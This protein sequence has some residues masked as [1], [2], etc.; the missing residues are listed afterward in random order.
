MNFNRIECDIIGTNKSL[1]GRA[2]GRLDIQ[3]DGQTQ[4][5]T[6]TH[7]NKL[8]HYGWLMSMSMSIRIRGMN[9]KMKSGEK[10]TDDDRNQTWYSQFTI[11]EPEPKN[12]CGFVI[13]CLCL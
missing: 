4:I 11:Y 9:E 6:Q 13:S 7:S 3:T 1:H 5:Q 2:N 10:K 8:M 12:V